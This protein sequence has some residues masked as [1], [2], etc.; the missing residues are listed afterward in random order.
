MLP[1]RLRSL[2]LGT[3]RRENEV[4]RCTTA[5]GE[6]EVPLSLVRRRRRLGVVVDVRAGEMVGQM[7]AIVSN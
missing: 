6:V 3:I 4:A 2:G 7:V 5:G 1:N